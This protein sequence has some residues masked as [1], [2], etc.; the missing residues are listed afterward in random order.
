LASSG[1]RRAR[2]T[3]HEHELGA[4]TR[5]RRLPDRRLAGLLDRELTVGDGFGAAG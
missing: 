4:W 3:S 5:A 2:L 1:E